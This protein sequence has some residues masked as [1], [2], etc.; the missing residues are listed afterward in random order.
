MSK[1]LFYV[2]KEPSPILIL[3]MILL[4]AFPMKLNPV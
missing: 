2:V 3:V 1:M 4:L